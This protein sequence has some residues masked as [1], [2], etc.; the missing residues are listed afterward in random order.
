[1]QRSMIEQQHCSTTGGDGPEEERLLYLGFGT[2][3]FVNNYR[4][5]TEP[6][7]PECGFSSF[8][9]SSWNIKLDSRR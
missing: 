9:Y 2:L 8:L 6:V 4:Y 7:A 3:K 1:M 5:V